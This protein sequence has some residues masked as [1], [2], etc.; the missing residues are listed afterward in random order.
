MQVAS[1]RPSQLVRQADLH[2]GTTSAAPAAAAASAAT[3]R[4][5]QTPLLPPPTNFTIYRGGKALHSHVA[6]LLIR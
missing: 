6:R 2:P 3:R 5:L 1:V 4:L